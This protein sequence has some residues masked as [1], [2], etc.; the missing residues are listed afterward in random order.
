MAGTPT[1]MCESDQP[2]KRDGPTNGLGGTNRSAP[3][4]V[5]RPPPGPLREERAEHPSGAPSADGLP[6]LPEPGVKHLALQRPPAKGAP[7]GPGWSPCQGRPGGPALPKRGVASEMSQ[8][9]EL[10]PRTG[11]K[12]RNWAADLPVGETGRAGPSGCH[13]TYRRARPMAA[14]SSRPPFGGRRRA[15][16][17]QLSDIGET[18]REPLEQVKV[19]RAV[20][21]PGVGLT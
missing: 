11:A 9:V 18:F 7:E 4:G 19:D 14:R 16:R 1:L 21:P 12:F 5:D 2:A 15:A 6:K 10:G 8:L 3:Y 17:I 13:S 20:G